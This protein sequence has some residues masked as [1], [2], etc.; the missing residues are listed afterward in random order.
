MLKNSNKIAFPKKYWKSEPTSCGDNWSSSSNNTSSTM[1]D[2]KTNIIGSIDPVRVGSESNAFSFPTSDINFKKT[3]Q[4][5][6]KTTNN[7]WGDYISK[8]NFIDMHFC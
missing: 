3:D 5:D 2:F 6:T 1:N 8:E 7:P 4:T